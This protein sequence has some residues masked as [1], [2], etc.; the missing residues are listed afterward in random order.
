[1][2]ARSRYQLMTCRQSERDHLL[3]EF[4]I[5][6]ALLQEATIEAHYYSGQNGSERAKVINKA[7]D[8]A[9]EYGALRCMVRLL[10]ED[11]DRLLTNF[12]AEDEE[13]DDET[14]DDRLKEW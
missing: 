6:F 13:C 12:L 4:P 11:P 3:S 8:A 5:A 7:L 14:D 2:K 9:A 10:R 1:M